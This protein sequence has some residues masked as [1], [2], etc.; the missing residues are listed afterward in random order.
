MSKTVSKLALTAS[1]L[2]AMAFTFSCSGDDDSG[3]EEKYS[4]CIKEGSCYE[5]PYTLEGC[6]SFGGMPSNNCPNGG[7]GGS[8]S[9]VGSQ[10]GGSSSSGGGGI[11]PSEYLSADRQVYMWDDATKKFNDGG[12]VYFNHGE[13]EIG[14]IENG[15]LKLTLPNIKDDNPELLKEWDFRDIWDLT[16]THADPGYSILP[17]NLTYYYLEKIEVDVPGEEYDCRMSLYTVKSGKYEDRPGLYYFSAPGSITGTVTSESDVSSLNYNLSFSEGWNF[18][19]NID[20]PSN[21]GY[22]MRNV[23]T[24]LPA[25]NTLEWGLYCQD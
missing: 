11:D 21:N 24:S 16:E 19:Y 5:G 6:N 25:G 8:S 10:G 1:V 7:S 20:V 12:T 22:H 2:L 15:K 17:A 13:I 23:T 14:K 9:S 3:G 4:Y 18:V